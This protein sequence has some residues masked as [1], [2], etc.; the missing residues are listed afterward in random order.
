MKNVLLLGV[1]L[2]ASILFTLGCSS[3]TTRHMH[4]SDIAP[5]AEATLKM[6]TVAN[7]N[8]SL[9]L[10]VKH[11]APPSRLSGDASTYVV[12]LSPTVGDLDLYQNM[13]S[14]I[15]DKNLEANFETV[16]PHRNFNLIITAEK[17]AM[18]NKPF[19][20][21]IMETTLISLAE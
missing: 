13:G 3:V 11:L 10:N 20:K 7:N 12:W 2:G 4:G 16:V 5:A 18:G 19:G 8:T 15:V 21:K 1:S 9:N 6:D 17:S 14:L